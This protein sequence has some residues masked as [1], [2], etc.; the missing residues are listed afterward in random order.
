MPAFSFRHRILGL[1]AAL[2]ITACTGP[3]AAAPAAAAVDDFG[4]TLRT[5]ATPTRV[6]SL[7]PATTDIVFAIGAG[8]RLVGRTSWD[9]RDDSVRAVPDLGPGLRPNVEAVLA[10]RPDLV[11][12]YAGE[13]NRAAARALRAAG[14]ATLSLRIDRIADFRRATRL[15]GAALGDSVRARHVVDSVDATLDRVRRA[16]AG[17]PRRT[18][19]WRVWERP[20]LTIGG[21]SYLTELVTIAGGRNIYDS[22]PQASPQVAME[23]V[24]R[25]NPDVILTSPDGAGKFMATSAW[26]AVPAVRDGRV[27]I[28]DTTLV[29][30]PS[31]RLG[32][33]AV[34][35]ARLLH[36]DVRP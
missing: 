16:T 3:E 7:N 9:L 32:E 1:T 17:L 23:D 33:A 2:A 18:T 35:L 27:L 14:I 20:L 19:F 22:L 21:G 31:V 24:V 6:V 12:L 10:A 25:R 11:L 8:P 13:D 5:G 29:G 30:R 26:R 36:P 4:D 34:S 28:V 15:V